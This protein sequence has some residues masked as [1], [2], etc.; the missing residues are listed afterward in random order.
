MALIDSSGNV[1]DKL[2]G[3]CNDANVPVNIFIS[4]R[5]EYDSD[6]PAK[7]RLSWDVFMPRKL[8]GFECDEPIFSD[9]P[10]ELRKVVRGQFIPLYEVAM[11]NLNGIA[12]GTRDKHYYWEDPN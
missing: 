10:E 12:D 4:E 3:L 2:S 11:R 7:W 6:W 8:S 5:D 1:I 9:D